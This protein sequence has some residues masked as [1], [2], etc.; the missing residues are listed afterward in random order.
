MRAQFV[1]REA[2]EDEEGSSG[3]MGRLHRDLALKE[4]QT[5]R[6]EIKAAIGSA[7]RSAGQAGR[8][9][10][11]LSPSSSLVQEGL[12]LKPPPAAGAGST[13]VSAAAATAAG[14]APAAPTE[15]WANFDNGTDAWG[16]FK[17]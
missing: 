4:G 12:Q 9:L 5:M 13:Q 3:E 2:E 6:L 16:D 10:D 15:D 8:L 14:G 1:R 7:S 11:R 17:G